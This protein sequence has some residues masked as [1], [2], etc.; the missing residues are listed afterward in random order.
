MFTPKKRGRATMRDTSVGDFYGA[1]TGWLR[2]E[3]NT[4]LMEMIKP[5]ETVN[6][7]KSNPRCNLILDFAP[8]AHR[9][10]Q[11]CPNMIVGFDKMKSAIDR[12]HK[13]VLSKTGNG[14]LIGSR[15]YHLQLIDAA[16]VLKLG[17]VKYRELA[18]DANMTQKFLSKA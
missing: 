9:I 13:R 2:D 18:K 12:V 6:T 5:M 16:G 8:L 17:M 3:C 11:V 1:L 7:K 15:P 14:I 10:V 4:D